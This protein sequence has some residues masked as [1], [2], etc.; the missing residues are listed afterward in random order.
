MFD[1]C[2][3]HQ[4]TLKIKI[5]TKKMDNCKSVT[6]IVKFTGASCTW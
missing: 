4:S 3:R 1:D 2:S 5:R 6:V